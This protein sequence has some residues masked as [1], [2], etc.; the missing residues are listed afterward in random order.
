MNQSSPRRLRADG[1]GGSLAP[2][3]GSTTERRGFAGDRN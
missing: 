2:V 1:C 3:C